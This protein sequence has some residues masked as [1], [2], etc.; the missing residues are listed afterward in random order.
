MFEQSFHFFGSL[1]CDVQQ[2]RMGSFIKEEKC[3]FDSNNMKLAVDDPRSLQLITITIPEA[4]LS[5]YLS[6][7]SL[8]QLKV[9]ENDEKC[10]E[11]L[12]SFE[13]SIINGDGCKIT[14]C[15]I[16]SDISKLIVEYQTDV[17]I[18]KDVTLDVLMEI[19]RYLKHYN[20]Y[21]NKR[22]LKLNSISSIANWT[23]NVDTSIK[24]CIN[25]NG[26]IND[27][28]WD[29]F[30]LRHLSKKGLLNQVYQACMTNKLDIATLKIKIGYKMTGL[31]FMRLFHE[32]DNK[33][34][35][36]DDDDLAD[37][38]QND[39]IDDDDDVCTIGD[40]GDDED[41]VDDSHGEDEKEKKEIKDD[42]IHNRNNNEDDDVV[43]VDGTIV[44]DNI[45]SVMSMYLGH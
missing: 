32:D 25:I 36:H 30:Y 3:M 37:I 33:H 17:I 38:Q 5:T 2:F 6:K 44:S 42:R 34:G 27:E 16:P 20:N 13:F 26:A 40:D 31:D 15:T 14:R 28:E 35:D 11:Q 19:A 7:Y 8:L 9:A 4:S 22:G 41:Q 39:N 12:N 29:K 43:V 45:M 23:M 1:N 24:T 10:F 21:Y 18:I